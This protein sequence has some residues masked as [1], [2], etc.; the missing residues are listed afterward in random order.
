MEVSCPSLRARSWEGG[1]RQAAPCFATRYGRGSEPSREGGQ[2]T[3]TARGKERAIRRTT[4]ASA[5]VSAALLCSLWFGGC[6]PRHRLTERTISVI[7]D[8]RRGT[9][10]L[11]HM[12][13]PSSPQGDLIVFDQPLVTEAG[14]DVGNN[15]GFCVRTRPGKYSECQWTMTLIDGAISVLGREAEQ[16]AS[17]VPVVGGTDAYRGASGELTTTPNGDGT[18]RQIIIIKSGAR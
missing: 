5:A 13:G 8:A 3:F 18:F 14:D 10:S 4:V 12:G 16:G 1:R 9:K 11:V 15:S 17:R 2:M 7:A 6:A